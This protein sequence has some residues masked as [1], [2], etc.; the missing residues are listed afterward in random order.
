[1]IHKESDKVF[2]LKNKQEAQPRCDSF[3][4]CGASKIDQTNIKRLLQK[5]PNL[6]IQYLVCRSGGGGGGGVEDLPCNKISYR[7]W[8]PSWV[9]HLCIRISY[10]SVMF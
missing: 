8:I 5:N 3:R 2:Q 7:A 10:S 6:A 4:Q 1:M 9:C